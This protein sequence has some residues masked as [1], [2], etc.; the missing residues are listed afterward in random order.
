MD[1]IAWRRYDVDI[2]IRKT[3]GGLTGTE[4]VPWASGPDPSNWIGTRPLDPDACWT[5]SRR[6]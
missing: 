3:G 5:C 6:C 2:G 4:R 1:P